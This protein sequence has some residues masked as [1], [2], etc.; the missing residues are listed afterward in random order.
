MNRSRWRAI[1]DE[2]CCLPLSFTALVGFRARMEYNPRLLFTSS[3]GF[4]SYYCR[5]LRGFM[6]LLSDRL[7]RSSGLMGS[8]DDDKL[9]FGTSR[10]L[11]FVR[12]CSLP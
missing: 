1:V 6:R 7:A 10:Q 5:F 9:R 11:A 2:T 3:D 4:I 8:A 12:A